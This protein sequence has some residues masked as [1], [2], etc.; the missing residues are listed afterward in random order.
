MPIYHLSVF[1]GPF[2]L[3]FSLSLILLV[4]PLGICYIFYITYYPVVH[5]YS[6]MVFFNLPLL[7]FV[8][9]SGFLLLFYLYLRAS[10]L[11]CVQSTNTSIEGILCCCFSVLYREHFSLVLRIPLCVCTSS[12]CFCCLELLAYYL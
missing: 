12:I 11:I 2:L 6:V 10:F 5:G 3:F 1:L 7:Y 8:L 9:Y 4:V